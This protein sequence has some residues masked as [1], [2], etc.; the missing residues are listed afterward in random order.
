VFVCNV[1]QSHW[2]SIVVVN[3]FLVFDRYVAEDNDDVSDKAVF[4]DDTILALYEL[5]LP[6][7]FYVSRP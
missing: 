3:P 2:L 4:S 5:I 6:L 1:N 7:F